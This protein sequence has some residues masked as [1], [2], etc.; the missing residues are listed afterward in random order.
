M[1]T[2]IL[3]HTVKVQLYACENLCDFSKTWPLNKSMRF[4]MCFASQTH[5]LKKIA[6]YGCMITYWYVQEVIKLT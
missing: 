1:R 3:L 2:D 4:F 6:D 5:N